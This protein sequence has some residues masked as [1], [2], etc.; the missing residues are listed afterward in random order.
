MKIEVLCLLAA[1][2]G[3]ALSERQSSLKKIA[4][5]LGNGPTQTMVIQD[6]LDTA[7]IGMISNFKNTVHPSI[8]GFF[9]TQKFVHKTG[10]VLKSVI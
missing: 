3:L 5:L 6:W 9:M 4:A 7:N 8:C 1:E 10:F 2:N